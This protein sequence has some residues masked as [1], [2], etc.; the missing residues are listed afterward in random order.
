MVDQGLTVK[1]KDTIDLY[2]IQVGEEAKKI[3]L[4]LSIKAREMGLNVLASF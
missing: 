4:P 3:A 2:F 1:N